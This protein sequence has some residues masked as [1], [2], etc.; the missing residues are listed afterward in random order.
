MYFLRRTRGVE[1]EHYMDR[2]R[3]DGDGVWENPLSHPTT[4]GF[5]KLY[6]SEVRAAVEMK[7]EELKDPSW[8]YRMENYYR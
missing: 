1:V 5:P 4:L 3:I 6:D 7:E 2:H 8:D